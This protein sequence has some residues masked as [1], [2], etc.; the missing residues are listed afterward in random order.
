MFVSSYLRES[1]IE[2]HIAID[3]C[4]APGG[5][6]TLL[7]SSLPTDCI[8]IA[9]EP[10]SG[11]ANVLREN[12]LRYGADETIVTSAYPKHLASTGL[13]ADIILVDAPCSGEGM[14]RKEDKSIQDWSLGNVAMCQMRQRDILD[15][16][17]K[18]LRPGGLLIY[19]TCT[20]NVSEN[21]EQLEYLRKHYDLEVLNPDVPEG[22]DIL[23]MDGVYRFI[24]GKVDSE[25]FTSFAVIKADEESLENRKGKGKP[26]PSTSKPSVF[27]GIFDDHMDY[28]YNF[29]ENWYYLSPEGVALLGSFEKTKGVRVL[30][31]GVPLGE[32]KGKDLIPAHGW[33]CSPQLSTKMPYPSV[34][35]DSQQAL[36]FL[37]RERVELD[38]YNGIEVVTYNRLPIGVVKNLGNRV[39]TLYPKEMAIRNRSL[40]IE[41]IPNW[42]G[43]L[44]VLS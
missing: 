23:V 15:E 44:E 35:L 42:E 40:S 12:V 11:R 7:R 43:E 38:A 9:N 10:D 30:L 5:K 20:Y 14:F 8:L 33:V 21:D 3:L 24:P 26:T 19:S 32:I 25:G 17:W 31:G 34:E 27:S 39:N 22:S 1:G 29:G 6:T 28:V 4:A 2:P 16:A 13:Q 36:N 18:M 37:K 41:D